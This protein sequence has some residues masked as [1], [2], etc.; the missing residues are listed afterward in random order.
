MAEPYHQQGR[1]LLVVLAVTVAVALAASYAA[2][3]IFLRHWARTHSSEAILF[4]PWL[5]LGLVFLGAALLVML[6]E[7]F[8]LVLPL[9]RGLVN[10]RL[11]RSA[12]AAECYQ[13]ALSRYLRGGYF[14]FRNGSRLMGIGLF[15]WKNDALDLTVDEAFEFLK[16]MRDTYYQMRKGIIYGRLLPLFSF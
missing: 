12:R 16:N 2:F 7:L 6:T 11:G 14:P 10:E 5:I 3:L 9:A 13:N 1:R 15:L 8:I 4:R